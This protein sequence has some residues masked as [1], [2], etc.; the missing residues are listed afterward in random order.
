MGSVERME[1]GGGARE[2][3]G[4]SKRGARGAQRRSRESVE[5]ATREDGF[6]AVL[7]GARGDTRRKTG[8]VQREGRVLKGHMAEVRR[9]NSLISLSGASASLRNMGRGNGLGGRGPSG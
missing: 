5:E 6:R 9:N 8:L 7:R 2:V 1:V 4:K 3:S